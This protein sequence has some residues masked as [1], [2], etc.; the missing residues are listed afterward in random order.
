MSTINVYLITGFLGSGKTTFLNQVI[1]QI[2]KNY[3]VMIL[4]NEFGEISV[5]GTLVQS[6]DLEVLEITKGSIF[7][8]CVKTD[9]IKGLYE[10]AQK[11]V[12]NILLVEATGVANPEDMKRDLGLPIFQGKFSFKEQICIVDAVNFLDTYEVY[13]AVE[14]QISSSTLFIINKIDL[15]TNEKI[16]QVE[17]LIKRHQPNARLIKTTFARVNVKEILSLDEVD[18]NVIDYGKLCGMSEEELESYIE[19]L[20]SEDKISMTPP[21]L[22]VSVSYD[23]GSVHVSGISEIKKL[24]D[25]LP[26]GVL[27]AK[28][29]LVINGKSYLYN[30]VMGQSEIVEYASPVRKN[31]ENVLVVIAPP[32]TMRNVEE[33]MVKYGFKK[34]G[35]VN[36]TKLLNG[37]KA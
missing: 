34:I 29:F 15:A 25:E 11:Y 24:T 14:K 33:L 5:D 36:R 19:E 23:L 30:Y 31:Q 26:R 20:L 22:L 16:S 9:F 8:V 28:G 21:D 17:E 18:I 37:F 10:I 32:D 12:P 7:C 6:E 1:K 27:R 3:K 13:A 2:P 4:M 35:E